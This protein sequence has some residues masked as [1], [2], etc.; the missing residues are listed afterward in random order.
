MGNDQP[1]IEWI[2]PR[3]S[4]TLRLSWS[5]ASSAESYQIYRSDSENGSFTKIAELNGD[6]Y[7]DEKVAPGDV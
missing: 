3:G 2:Q 5:Q 6:K 7:D 1:E 4:N